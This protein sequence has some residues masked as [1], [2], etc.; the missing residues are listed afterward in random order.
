MNEHLSQHSQQMKIM[1]QSGAP[2]R[3][4]NDCV[5]KRGTPNRAANECIID[6]IYIH[7]R[8]TEQQ[9]LVAC[10]Q[11]VPTKST[12]MQSINSRLGPSLY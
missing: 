3:A 2:N 9:I 5:S 12:D 1:Y 10:D 11:D 7:A 4:A 6:Y 8:T